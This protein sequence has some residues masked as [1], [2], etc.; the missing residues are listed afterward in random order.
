MQCALEEAGAAERQGNCSSRALKRGL[1]PKHSLCG[2][3]VELSA[4]RRAVAA[5]QVLIA[6]DGANVVGHGPLQHS[7]AQHSAAQLSMAL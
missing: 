6:P 2:R 4:W 7:T 5:G 3:E 1:T